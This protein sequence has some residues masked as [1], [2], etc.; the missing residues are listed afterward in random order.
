[1]SSKFV[2]TRCNTESERP[3]PRLGGA[4]QTVMTHCPRCNEVTAHRIKAT[5]SAGP[6]VPGASARNI[7]DNELWTVM[8]QRLRQYNISEEELFRSTAETQDRLIVSLSFLPD[9]HSRL[10][11]MIDSAGR[12]PSASAAPTAFSPSAGVSPARFPTANMA[13]Y[14]SGSG[15]GSANRRGT[16]PIFEGPSG[17][18]GL[19]FEGDQIIARCSVYPH[20]PAEFW[21]CACNVLV[22]SRCHVQGIHKDHPFIT[23]RLAAESHVRDVTQWNERCRTQLNVIASVMNNLKHAESLVADAA[24]KEL[25][26]LEDVVQTIVND[27]LRWK[28]QLKADITAQTVTQQSSIAHS[29][30]HTER[31]YSLYA[32]ALSKAEP[33]MSHI[34]P[35]ENTDKGGEEWALRVLDLVSKLKH[36]NSEAIPMPKITAPRI[37][38]QATPATHME[39]VKCVSMPLGVRLPDLLDPGYFNFPTPSVSARL[40]FTLVAPDDAAAKGILLYNGRTLTRSQDIV[41]SHHLVLASQVF[42]SGVTSW[43]VHID[44]MGA[45]TGRLLAGIT[46][47]GSDG[48]GVVW[49]GLRI[50]GP[51]DGESRTLDERYQWRPG[52]V[53]RFHLELDAPACYLNCFYDR[54]AVARIPLPANG[55]GWVPAFSVFGPQDQVTVVPSTTTQALNHSNLR[56]NPALAAGDTTSALERQEHLITSLQNQLNSVATR[57]DHEVYR[58]HDPQAEVY[59]SPPAAAPPNARYGRSASP[60]VQ[61]PSTQPVYPTTASAPTNGYQLPAGMSSAAVVASPPQP[62]AAAAARRGYPR[63][64]MEAYTPELRRIIRY[65][66]DSDGGGNGPRR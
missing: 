1:M 2:C 65:V 40:P 39:L 46:V 43:E 20:L 29:L 38:A 28:E 7:T 23:L 55:H 13:P 12:Q 36:V 15:I 58:S 33:L 24:G 3:V 21:C 53:L 49:D 18:K 47:N 50:V 51:N 19:S 52:T 9:E 4:D 5:E 61:L 44:R 6:G 59:S 62:A 42:Y 22:S 32:D 60:V 11:F 57:L 16:S 10:R 27:L 37:S 66:E 17:V 30:G 54:E 34:P 56:R 41:P 25:N 31:L 63:D 35:V 48:E 8:V 64:P 14:G 26:N 45:G